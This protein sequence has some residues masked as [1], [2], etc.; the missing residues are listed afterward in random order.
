MT[1][2]EDLISLMSGAGFGT[3][4]TTLFKGAKAV[5]PAGAGPFVSFTETGGGP[6]EGTHNC[7]DVPA[8]VK[9]SAQIVVRAESYDVAKARAVELYALLYPVRNRLVNGTY[10]HSVSILQEPFDLGL[11]DVGR[12]RVAFNINVVKRYSPA[13]S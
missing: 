12:P 4:G 9:P 5:I 6:P 3:Y 10:W 11:D 13:T 1:F 7:I 2:A 8:Y